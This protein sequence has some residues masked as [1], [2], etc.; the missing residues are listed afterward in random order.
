MNI[1]RIAKA[2]NH[3]L[4]GKSSL[5]VS[6]VPTRNH[7]HHDHHDQHDQHDHGDHEEVGSYMRKLEV[8]HKEVGGNLVRSLR[9]DNNEWMNFQCRYRAVLAAINGKMREVL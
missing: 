6:F 3:K 4:R 2:A 5:N 8:V 1:A 9:I 7:D